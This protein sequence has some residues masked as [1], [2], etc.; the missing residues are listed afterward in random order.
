[1]STTIRLTRMGRKKRPFYRLIVTDSRKRRDGAYLENLGHY[2]PFAE[3]FALELHHEEILAWLR[4]GATMSDT[5]KSLIKREGILYRWEL[6]RQGVEGAELEAKVAAWKS[7]FAS[8][9]DA[10][11]KAKLEAKRA[12]EAAEA[13]K[14]AEEEEE[15]RKAEE[16]E[17]AAAT[18]AAEAEAAEASAEEAPAEETAED[19]GETAADEGDKGEGE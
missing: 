5:A 17:A 1:M 19:A 16:A 14:K 3:P 12:A 6:E 11:L 8:R 7:E 10:K 9:E 18:A 15:A 4:K 13:A 2:D